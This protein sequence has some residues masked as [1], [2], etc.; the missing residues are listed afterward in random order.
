MS[1]GKRA[2]EYGEM[3]TPGVAEREDIY[4]GDWA[5][6]HSVVVVYCDNGYV[7]IRSGKREGSLD[8]QRRRQ[9]TNGRRS[10]TGNKFTS[11]EA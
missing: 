9:G 11:N 3:K 10:P 2:R 6:W 4:G 1:D 7:R 5:S 8:F